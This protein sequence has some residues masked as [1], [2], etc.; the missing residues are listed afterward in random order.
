MTPDIKIVDRV[1]WL[2]L[3]RCR[4]ERIYTGITPDVTRRFQDHCLGK[5]IYTRRLLPLELIGALPIGSKGQASREERLTKRLSHAE[6]LAL[7]AISRGLP[8]WNSILEAQAD[9]T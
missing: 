7:A 3:L 4:N 6:K 5:S 9:H 2:Y 8:S 1:W